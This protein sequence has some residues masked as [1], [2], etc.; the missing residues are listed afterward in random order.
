[1]STVKDRLGNVI[2][3]GLNLF[4][5]ATQSIVRVTSVG[6]EEVQGKKVPVVKMELCVALL[7]APVLGD[8]ICV[9][10]PDEGKAVEEI[11]ERASSLPIRPE[12][13]RPQ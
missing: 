9:H 5:P 10:T 1:M 8:F 6:T 4:W 3:A 2:R 11:L 12:L 13:V 7:E